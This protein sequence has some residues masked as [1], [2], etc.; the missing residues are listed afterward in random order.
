[1]RPPAQGNCKVV[2]KGII[3]LELVR[4]VLISIGF[5]TGFDGISGKKVAALTPA[6]FLYVN[7]QDIPTLH[8]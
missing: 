3:V 2:R 5:N 1:V 6:I 8:S 4:L 7:S